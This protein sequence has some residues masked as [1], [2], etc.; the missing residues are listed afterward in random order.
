MAGR[1]RRAL[2]RDKVYSVARRTSHSVRDTVGGAT[3]RV[4]DYGQGRVA[5]ARA[6]HRNEVVPDEKLVARVRAELGRAVSHPG[7]IHVLRRREKDQGEAA[8]GVVPAF[9]LDQPQLAAIEV[10]R[11]VQIGHADH[12]VKVFHPDLPALRSDPRSPPR[13]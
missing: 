3:H 6:A 4:R 13:S 2:T 7:A 11:R 12:G 10:D 8:L 9:D 5:R 1:R